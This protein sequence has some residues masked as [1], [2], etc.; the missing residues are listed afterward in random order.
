MISIHI[1]SQTEE[2]R[3]DVFFYYQSESKG[4]KKKAK[5]LKSLFS[6]KYKK[7][8]GREYNGTI[9]ARPLYVMRTSEADP[10]YIELANIRNIHDRERIASPRNRQLIADWILEGFLL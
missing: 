5:E 4:S 6:D 8:Q 1:D 3:Q 9:S 7:F 10:I 2:N